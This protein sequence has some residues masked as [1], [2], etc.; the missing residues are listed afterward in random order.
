MKPQWTVFCGKVAVS[1]ILHMSTLDVLPTG[2]LHLP[3][4]TLLKLI[5]METLYHSV[6][7]A[8]IPRIC[9]YVTIYGGS[10]VEPQLDSGN[11][12]TTS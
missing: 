4:F 5:T 10:V 9:F 12:I 8:V 2:P 11:I 7:S 3:L 1:V 6:A